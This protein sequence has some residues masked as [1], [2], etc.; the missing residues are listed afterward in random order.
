MKKTNEDAVVVAADARPVDVTAMKTIIGEDLNRA[1]VG[2]F[3]MLRA[4]VGLL[5]Y[6][7][8]SEHGEWED[9]LLELGKGKSPRTLQIY[10]KQAR[11]LCEQ[12]G[13]T[14]A[15]AWDEARHIDASQVT[16]LLLAAPGEPR[17]IGAGEQPA[18]DPPAKKGR[19]AK[20]SKPASGPDMP[21]QTFAQMLLDF[22]EQRKRAKAKDIEPKKPLTKKEKIETAIAEAFRVV[23]LT[24][25]W[26]ADGTWALL[27]DEELESAMAGLRAAA[28]KI[29]DEFRNRRAKI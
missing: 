22:M 20:K 18:E 28:D 29:R 6:K 9:R 15:Q 25:D 21:T 11:T 1:E 10:M 8:L 26:V 5:V 19:K 13:I 17:Q 16:E 3:C 7:E 14:P 12:Y 23:N 2:V 4:G 27:P 24:A